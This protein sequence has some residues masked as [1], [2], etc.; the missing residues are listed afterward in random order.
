MIVTAAPVAPIE[1]K[2]LFALSSVMSLPVAVIVAA[3]VTVAAPFCVTAP[4]AVTLSESAEIESKTIPSTSA[5]LTE[6][7]STTLIFAKLLSVFSRVIFSAVIVAVPL[8]FKA[9]V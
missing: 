6:E 3:P 7:A 5:I 9:A 2:A 1:P 4:P 8:I